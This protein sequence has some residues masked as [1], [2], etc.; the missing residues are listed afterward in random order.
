LSYEE[1]AAT[2]GLKKGTVMSRLNRARRKI[3]AS[4]EEKSHDRP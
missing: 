4:L 1:L 2:L 3:A